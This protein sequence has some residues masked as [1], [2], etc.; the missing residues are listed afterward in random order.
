MTGTE[1]S[2]ETLRESSFEDFYRNQRP[3]LVRAL[4]LATG[5]RDLAAEAADEAMVRAFARWRRVR[6]YRNP[7]GWTYR[8]GL[9]WARSRHRK[10]K[11]EAV[12][13]IADRAVHDAEP[14][15]AMVA[16]LAR[17]PYPTRSVVVA[18]YYLQMS[19]EEIASALDIP[20]GTV[21]SRIG[22][23]LDELR[24]ALEVTS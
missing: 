17:L 6:G 19:Q 12:G 10:L 11:R 21:K 4:A 13:E 23:G 15:V 18:R 3:R 1:A 14:D 24:T 5:D 2:L 16:A 22:R 20:L 7:A 8:V 9:N